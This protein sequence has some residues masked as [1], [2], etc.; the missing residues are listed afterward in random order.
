MFPFHAVI[1]MHRL[2][3]E[4]KIFQTL[5]SIVPSRH[6]YFMTFT[7]ILPNS[8]NSEKHSHNLSGPSNICLFKLMPDIT[9]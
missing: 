9:S 3:S 2:T 6:K 4:T 8:L 5:P 1:Q 7:L